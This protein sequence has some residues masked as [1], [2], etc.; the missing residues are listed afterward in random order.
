MADLVYHLTAVPVLGSSP[1][2]ASLILLNWGFVRSPILSTHAAAVVSHS[3]QVC[4]PNLS[5]VRGEIL[6]THL[7]CYSQISK[8]S[9]SCLEWVMWV[10]NPIALTIAHML[11][12][13]LLLCCG[14]CR[15]FILLQ[16]MAVMEDQLRNSN[17]LNCSTVFPCDR[18]SSLEKSRNQIISSLFS[19]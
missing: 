7:F 10:D 9:N 16:C 18:L 11:V 8:E 12:F 4:Q 6:L 1:Q 13:W 5:R 15:C 19:P 17:L 3:F 2:I 14:G